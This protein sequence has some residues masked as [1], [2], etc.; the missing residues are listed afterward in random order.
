MNWT[1]CIQSKPKTHGIILTTFNTTYIWLHERYCHVVEWFGLVTGFIGLLQLVTTRTIWIYRVYNSLWHALSL[2]CQLCLPYSSGNGFHQRM[3]PFLWIPELS[4]CLRHSNS[5][6]S[7][8]QL[9]LYQEDLSRVTLCTPFK[10]A[11][12]SEFLLSNKTSYL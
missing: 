1:M 5:R 9:Q 10:K 6:L 12:S 8:K 2:L 3:F 7:R 4:P 11:V